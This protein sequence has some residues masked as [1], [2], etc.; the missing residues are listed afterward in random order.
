MNTSTVPTSTKPNI[1]VSALGT[2]VRTF[3]FRPRT[4]TPVSVRRRMQLLLK[5]V[6]HHQRQ[7]EHQ[8]QR[9]DPVQ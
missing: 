3:R 1:A 5:V 9:R 8:S 4:V 7:H 6:P 2:F